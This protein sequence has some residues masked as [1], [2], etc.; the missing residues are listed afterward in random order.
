METYGIK[1]GSLINPQ[2]PLTSPPPN[3][4]PFPSLRPKESCAAKIALPSFA[5]RLS[6]IRPI[7]I[8]YVLS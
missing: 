8:G 7:L 5:G 3:T 2:P 6:A 4:H 1:G